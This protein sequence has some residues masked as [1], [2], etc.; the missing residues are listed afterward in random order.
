[1]RGFRY[2]RR[3]FARKV[4]G[5]ARRATGIILVKRVILDQVNIADVTSVSY[6]NPTNIGLCVAEESI[7]EEIESNGTTIAECPIYSRLLSM[8]LDL[9]FR[10]ST[11]VSN[12]V[13]W[14]IM[15]RPDGEALVTSLADAQFH[16]SDDTPTQ[17]EVR[18]LTLAKGII[19]I[20]P[21]TATTSK[22]IFISRDAIRRVGRMNEQDRLE[23]IVAKDAAGTTCDISGM[24]NLYFRANA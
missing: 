8:K 23:L 13:R 1:M 21:S 9:I 5:I 17:R 2:R 14:M 20:N 19:A 16:T 12:L 11:S 22:R 18:S 10:G 3:N 24:G 7:E 4:G 15:K 6:D